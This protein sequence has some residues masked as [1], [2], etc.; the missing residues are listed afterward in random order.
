MLSRV[1]GKIEEHEQKEYEYWQL[2]GG[3]SIRQYHSYY[4]LTWR[5]SFVRTIMCL[6]IGSIYNKCIPKKSI[7]IKI[8]ASIIVKAKK[9]ETRILWSMRKAI[10]I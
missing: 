10:R 3:Q 1:D 5:N 9:L 8:R 6:M 4:Y 2:Y 7:N